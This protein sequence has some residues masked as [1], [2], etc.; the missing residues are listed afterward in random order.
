MVVIIKNI[1]FEN[2]PSISYFE[3]GASISY[4]ND[5]YVDSTHLYSWHSQFPILNHFGGSFTAMTNP[6]LI[7]TSWWMFS[8]SWA[9]RVDQRIIFMVG[10]VTFNM[11]S[12]HHWRRM[13]L[14]GMSI[15]YKKRCKN[16]PNENINTDHFLS[17][18]E[19]IE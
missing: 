1:N 14:M 8:L 13:G 10:I 7:R 12:L 15:K 2:L 3:I 5:W 6:T 11:D 19:F 16:D 17:Q 4:A 18:L 9:T